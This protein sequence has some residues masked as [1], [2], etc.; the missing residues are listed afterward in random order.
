MV[1][2]CV[3]FDLLFADVLLEE[4]ARADVIVSVSWWVNVA[5]L[6]PG[7][8]M[9]GAVAQLVGKVL[10]A[11]SS[12]FNWASSG[13][14]VF[15]P[16]QNMWSH[17]FNDGW[18]PATSAATLA[19]KGSK[20]SVTTSRSVPRGRAERRPLRVFPFVAAVSPHSIVLG[21]ERCNAT[22]RFDSVIE[23]ER[24]ALLSFAG[25]YSPQPNST[26]FWL[27]LCAVVACSTS[28]SSCTSIYF[29]TF[30]ITTAS[31]FSQLDLISDSPRGGG[32]VV[33]L[34]WAVDGNGELLFNQ[35]AVLTKQSSV[36][37]MARWIMMTDA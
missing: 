7:V 35:G 27:D 4:L 37:S 30:N 5:P 20:D 17:A 10:V 24:Y 19:V 28:D 31:V 9:H 14:A 1:G 34:E 33:S 26:L 15:A 12:G 36:S 16:R 11:P 32:D 2:L 22:V 21:D 29:G 25:P 23:G 3:C 6:A 8:A 18:T 13:S